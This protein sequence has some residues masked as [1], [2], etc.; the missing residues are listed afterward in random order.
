MIFTEST[1]FGISVGEV[2]VMV[3][4]DAIPECDRRTDRQTV[5]R[6]FRSYQ[7]TALAYIAMPPG[8]S[9]HITTI[10]NC[11]SNAEKSA[12]LFFEI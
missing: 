11:D 9:N 1:V 12:N 10:R 8:K 6:T 5:G 4:F 3:L 7:Y 2:I